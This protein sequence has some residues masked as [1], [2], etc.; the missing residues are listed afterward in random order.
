M[1]SLTPPSESGEAKL[2]SPPSSISTS[3]HQKAFSLSSLNKPDVSA[4]EQTGK[5]GE[6]GKVRGLFGKLGPSK[7][8]P[9]SGSLSISNDDKPIQSPPSTVTATPTP[10]TEQLKVKTAQSSTV[11]PSG[12]LAIP[13]D[14]DLFR[15]SLVSAQRAVDHLS[16]INTILTGVGAVTSLG[17]GWV[18]GL[19]QG[20]QLVL[21]MLDQ[22]KTIN[23][24]KV[25]AIRLVSLTPFF[26]AV[27]GDMRPRSSLPFPLSTSVQC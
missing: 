1:A 5:E 21:M 20:V 3:T 17:A 24:G 18:P 10:S 12:T 22:A 14:S 8:K 23:V 25:A 26:G 16:S 27:I 13:N 4:P 7:R 15:Q 19:A 11:T 2:S 9:S 6:K